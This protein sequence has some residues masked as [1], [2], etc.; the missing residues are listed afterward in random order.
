[1][2]T[3]EGVIIDVRLCQHRPEQKA[4]CAHLTKVYVFLQRG[5]L[6]FH[7]EYGKALLT[8]CDFLNRQISFGKKLIRSMG[9]KEK[10]NTSTS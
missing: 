1:M 3:G 8:V 5:L 4:K 7:S 10:R 9:R 2:S 6:Q